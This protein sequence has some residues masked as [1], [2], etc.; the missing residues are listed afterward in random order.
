MNKQKKT[1]RKK[2]S[3]F[4]QQFHKLD[5]KIDLGQE[6][7]SKEQITNNNNTENEV[8]DEEVEIENQIITSTDPLKA[9]I[10]QENKQRLKNM[11]E[12]EILEERNKLLTTLGMCIFE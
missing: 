2:K 9:T 6:S 3:L 11:S 7:H 4:A 12:S 10:D 8:Q 5:K 1:S